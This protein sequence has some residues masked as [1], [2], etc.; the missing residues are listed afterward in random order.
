[1]V[2]SDTELLL[3]NSKI[4]PNEWPRLTCSKE[5]IQNGL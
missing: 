1:M 5:V 4:N 3:T 2:L